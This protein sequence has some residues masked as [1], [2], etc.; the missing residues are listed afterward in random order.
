MP[1]TDQPKRGPGRPRLFAEPMRDCTVGL[2]EELIDEV[3]RWR[4]EFGHRTGSAAMR[5]MI[6][7][8]ARWRRG[9]LSKRRL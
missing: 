1:E 7:H 3:S 4:T 9:E 5:E 6:E 2:P 8:A